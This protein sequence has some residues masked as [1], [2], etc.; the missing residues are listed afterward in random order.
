MNMIKRIIQWKS[1]CS[2]I[3]DQVY[4]GEFEEWVWVWK[5]FNS[6]TYRSCSFK[7]LHCSL[8]TTASTQTNWNFKVVNGK[9]TEN[10]MMIWKIAFYYQKS[11]KYDELLIPEK[12][13]KKPKPATITLLSGIVGG[14]FKCNLHEP[15]QVLLFKKVILSVFHWQKSDSTNI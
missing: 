6:G 5:A 10:Y 12:K 3:L 4:G 7:C 15:L 9:L 13:P 8:L 1:S 14:K 11:R 2:A